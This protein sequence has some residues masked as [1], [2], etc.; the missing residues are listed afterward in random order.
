MSLMISDPLGGKGRKPDVE[1]STLAVE[2]YMVPHR[3]GEDWL[4]NEIAQFVRRFL[5]LPESAGFVLAVW[6][7][8]TY[9]F[10]EFEFTPYLNI[11]SPEPGCGKST[12]ANVIKSLSYQGLSLQGT[13]AAALR[14]IIDTHKPTLIID[15]WDSLDSEVRTDCR[16]FLNTGFAKDGTSTIVEGRKLVTIMSTFCPKAIIGRSTVALAEDTLSRCIPFTIQRAAATDNLEKF[17]EKGREEAAQLRRQCE[18]WAQHFRSRN[19]TVAPVF[20]PSFDGRQQDITEPLLV[21][22]DTVGGSWPHQVREALATLLDDRHRDELTPEN[23][24]LRAVRRFIEEKKLTRF[25][26]SH[27]FVV[28]ANQ[29]EER[30]WSEKPLTAAKLASMLRTYGVSP[31]QISHTVVA[32]IEK[33]YRGYFLTQFE[34]AFRRYT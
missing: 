17:R 15:E 3:G 1:P 13:T 30:P 21:I 28:W 33:N 26:W 23:H 14:R 9:V 29:Q 11:N 22:A 4:V 31:H 5:L 24:L 10:D 16:N 25:F 6:I 34:D 12:T 8:H 19:I 7:L 27:M 18:D 32:G 2:R 20:P